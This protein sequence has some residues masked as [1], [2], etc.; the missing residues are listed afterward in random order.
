M[1]CPRDR[2]ALDRLAADG[3]TTF[4]CRTC[5][6]RAVNVALLR[7]M[8]PEERLLELWTI[9]R[10]GDT[11]DAACPSCGHAMRRVSFGEAPTTFQLDGCVSCQILWFDADEL[12]AL[13]PDA[14]SPSPVL[15]A[16][17]PA[18]ASD[19][20]VWRH[21]FQVLNQKHFGGL[22]GFFF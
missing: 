1:N 16:P 18:D 5:G 13:A 4:A 7:R 3:A 11:G 17:V 12:R 2:A 14:S 15:D 8:M 9:V 21:F 10:A 19:Q 22:A 20:W 6:G